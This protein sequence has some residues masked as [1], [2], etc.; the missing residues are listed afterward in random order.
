MRQMR[1][2]VRLH[3]AALSTRQVGI[4]VGVA[5]AKVRMTLRRVAPIGMANG[6]LSEQ[7]DAALEKPLFTGEGKKTKHR[8]CADL[9]WAAIHQ[10]LK[11]K[12]SR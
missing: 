7:T 12:I 4:L 11:H 1:E 8:R 6:G 5:A 2:I 3:Q 9:D 10:E